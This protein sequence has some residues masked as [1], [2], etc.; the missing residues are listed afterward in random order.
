VIFASAGLFALIVGV[1]RLRGLPLDEIA[2]VAIS[3]VVSLV[4]EGLPV[5][6]TIAL[7]VGVQRMAR[8]QT[9]VRRSRRSR[10]LGSTTVICSDKTGR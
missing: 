5:A 3:Q 2:M 7:A 8:R 10:R 4:P 6:L 9:I 1:G